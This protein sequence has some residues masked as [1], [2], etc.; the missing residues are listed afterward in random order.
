MVKNIVLIGFMG[1]GKTLLS[2]QL[3]KQ[4]NRQRV[5]IDEA[6]E[7]KHGKTIADIFKTLG[8]AYFRAS[9]EAVVKE[10]ALSQ[11]LI[12]DCGGGIVINPANIK[13]LKQNGV[14]FLLD[15]SAQTIY[16]RL[17]N[18]TTRPLLNVPDPQGAIKALLDQRLPLYQHAADFIVDANDPSLEVPLVEILKK[19]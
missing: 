17:K 16:H 1:S 12:I 9:E 4:L 3:A 2:K 11:G 14:I 8:E 13:A 10:F 15:V 19:V 7:A 5:S 18:D 6:I